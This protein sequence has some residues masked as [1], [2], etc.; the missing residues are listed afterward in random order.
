MPL[1]TQTFKNLSTL[2][3]PNKNPDTHKIILYKK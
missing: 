1:Q 3:P 2:S